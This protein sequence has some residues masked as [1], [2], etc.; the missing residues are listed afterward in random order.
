METKKA[1]FL[2]IT[3]TF[4]CDDEE[5]PSIFHEIKF[6]LFIRQIRWKSFRIHWN[7]PDIV[8]TKKIKPDSKKIEPDSDDVDQENYL[9]KYNIDF[10]Y[11]SLSL[12]NK[13][14]IHA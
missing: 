11:F 3:L 8:E 13:Y 5:N 1:W 2:K 4:Y 7:V 10:I 12:I 9:F 14:H 6:S